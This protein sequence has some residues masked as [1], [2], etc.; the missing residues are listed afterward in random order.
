MVVQGQPRLLREFQAS[1]RRERRK[2]GTEGRRRGLA[3]HSLVPGPSFY[4]VGQGLLP[5]ATHVSYGLNLVLHIHW[6]ATGD[7]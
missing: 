6:I 1:Q 3:G 5:A 2:E 7:G 4:A